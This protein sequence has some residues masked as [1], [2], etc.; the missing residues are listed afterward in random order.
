MRSLTID[1]D[2][3]YHY[4]DFGGD[5]PPLVLVHGI[6]GSHI[7]WISVAPPL[8]ERFHVL[9]VDQIGFGFT[10]LAGRPADLSTQQ[11]YLDRFIGATAGGRASLIGHSM[12]GLV[13]MRQAAGAP[14]SVG[15]MVLIDPAAC[16]VRSNAPGVPT[17][18]MAA[19]G[20][21][22]AIGGRLA[23]LIP[24]SKGPEAMVVDALKRAFAGPIDAGFLG[25]HVELEAQRAGLPTPY[26]GYVEAWRSMRNQHAEGDRW[27]EEILLPIRAQTLL[28]YGTVDPLIR[29]R[30]FERLARLR[31]DWDT[32]PLVGVG[33][34]PHMEAPEIFLRATLGWLQEAPAATS[35]P[36]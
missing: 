16:L 29:Q 12:G 28:V 19:M 13:V 15:R 10:P 33:H 34:D 32:A 4:I 24:R 27:V 25:A 8:A 11:R 9:A 5:G 17:W 20:A 1:L 2:G 3:P 35:P 30:W 23:G 18:L 22:P 26:R 36:R 7:N 14:D 31:P 6:G 21:Y